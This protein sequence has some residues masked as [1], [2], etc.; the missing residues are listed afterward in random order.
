[1]IVVFVA[2]VTLAFSNAIKAEDW[3][4]R[5]GFLLIGIGTIVWVTVTRQFQDVPNWI[6]IILDLTGGLILMKNIGN[7]T[8]QNYADID[9]SEDDGAESHNQ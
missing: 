4:D 1:M 3:R 8:P 2:V 7:Q 9:E 6:K 5:I